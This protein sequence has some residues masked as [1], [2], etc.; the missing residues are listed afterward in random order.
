[1]LEVSALIASLFTPNHNL[2][3]W[4]LPCRSG[5]SQYHCPR[6]DKFLFFVCVSMH[7][8]GQSNARS[9]SSSVNITKAA[10]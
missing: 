6:C 5:A 9:V 4:L 10:Q 3:D 8:S 7:Q 1:M 2:L